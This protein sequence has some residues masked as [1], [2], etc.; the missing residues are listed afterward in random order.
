MR[1][2]SS[3][4][5]PEPLP[6]P[7][8]HSGSSSQQ[9]LIVYFTSEDEGWKNVHRTSIWCPSLLLSSQLAEH[10]SGSSHGQESRRLWWVSYPHSMNHFIEC[11]HLNQMP[12][13][14]RKPS[15]FGRLKLVTLDKL[16]GCALLM[17][18]FGWRFMKPQNHSDPVILNP[19]LG[20][21]TPIVLC[22]LVCYLPDLNS[23]ST[24]NMVSPMNYVK[25][26]GAV[27]E[28]QAIVAALKYS[29][30]S[31]TWASLKTRWLLR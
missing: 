19:W 14:L 22:R 27:S 17:D 31:S 6:H 30:K 26:L 18:R 24:V 7:T 3:C 12:S 11:V 15:T 4:I 20:L 25:P 28:K 5:Q 16:V 10:H 23:K 9:A 13:F 2:T 8:L 21:C 29:V 1:K